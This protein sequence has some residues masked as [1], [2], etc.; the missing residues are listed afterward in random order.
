MY[1]YSDNTK[2]IARYFSAAVVGSVGSVKCQ[3]VPCSGLY[4]F[5]KSIV[6][7]QMHRVSIKCRVLIYCTCHFQG[8]SSFVYFGFRCLQISSL[9]H[10]SPDP[11][12]KG[13][14]LFRLTFSFVLWKEKDTANKYHWHVWGV[15]A[16]DGPHWVCHSPGWCVLPRSTLPRLQDGP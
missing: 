9:S 7:P 1:I 10:F 12:G 11:R 16:E 15:L 3:I 4:L 2:N 13:S 6:A 5:S 14:Y 8:C